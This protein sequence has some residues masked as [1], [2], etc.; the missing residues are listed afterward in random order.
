MSN[1]NN[2]QGIQCTH[3]D[4]DGYCGYGCSQTQK[5][6]I[7]MLCLK[8]GNQEL[9]TGTCCKCGKCYNEGYHPA[10]AFRDR[11]SSWSREIY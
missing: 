8:C 3:K 9:K 11:F 1:N 10:I 4:A 6:C 5:T 7:P 2:Y